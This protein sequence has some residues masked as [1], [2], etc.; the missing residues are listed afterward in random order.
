M[1]ATIEVSPYVQIQGWIARVLPGGLIAV[2]VFGREY[3]GR[4]VRR[5]RLAG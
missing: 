4:P 5:A 3:V 2:R 1:V